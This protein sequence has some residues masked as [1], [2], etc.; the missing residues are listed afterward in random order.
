MSFF[1]QNAALSG[2][3]NTKKLYSNIP[4]GSIIVRILWRFAPPSIEYSTQ[5]GIHSG[6]LFEIGRK[7]ACLPRH[8]VTRM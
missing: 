6:L 8:P 5:T 4:A 3:S 1:G 2:Y 7:S